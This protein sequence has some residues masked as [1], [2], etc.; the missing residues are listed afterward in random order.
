MTDHVYW[1]EVGNACYWVIRKM[2]GREIANKYDPTKNPQWIFAGRYSA[3]FEQ[4]F[5]HARGRFGQYDPG[6]P[7]SSI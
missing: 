1:F 7:Y 5:E 4:G 2:G 6:V 3:D